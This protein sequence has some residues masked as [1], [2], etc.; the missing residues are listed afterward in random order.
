MATFGEQLRRERQLR[1][2]TLREVAE[3]TKVNLRYLE[4][5]ERNDF[6]HL[7]GGVFNKGFVRAYCEFIGLDAVAMV[8]AYLLEERAQAAR[9]EQKAEPEHVCTEQG[10]VY[11]KGRQPKGRSLVV[12]APRHQSG[13]GWLL[14][15]ACG[16]LAGMFL[17]FILYLYLGMARPKAPSR[18]RASSPVPS[19]PSAPRPP[20]TALQGDDR[21]QLGNNEETGD[22]GFRRILTNDAG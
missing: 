7:P 16:L 8:D 1:E 14:L 22:P 12:V 13:W 20:R 21:Q 4:A 3:A 15:A 18:P 10:P 9:K 5:L 6:D 19:G 11:R 2:I 17:G